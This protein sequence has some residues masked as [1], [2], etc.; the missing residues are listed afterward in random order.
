MKIE[1]VPQ[2]NGMIG[3]YGKEIAY[4]TDSNG[5]YTL[6]HSEGWEVKNIVNDQ[7]WDLIYTKIK[8]IHEQSLAEELS[9]LA[10]HMA[11]HQM[12]IGLLAKYVNRA[13]W[14]IKRHLKPK[15]FVKLSPAVLKQ[16][17]DVFEIEVDQLVCVPK[18]LTREQVMDRNCD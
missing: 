11:F 15:V 7:A 18:T 4:A 10:F 14:R 16:Y 3:E 12:D 17:A 9:P 13:V 1:D 8:K 5:N 2:E 6:V